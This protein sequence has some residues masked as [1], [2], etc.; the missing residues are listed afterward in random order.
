LKEAKEIQGIIDVE[1]I[2]DVGE[3]ISSIDD[4]TDRVGYVIA[5]AENAKNAIDICN[6]ALECIKV[7]VTDI[8]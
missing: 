4:S 3:T 5:R 1:I 6:Q 8:E 7:E 2:H